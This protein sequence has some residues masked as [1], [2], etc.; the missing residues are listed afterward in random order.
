MYYA[1]VLWSHFDRVRN[2]GLRY[3]RVTPRLVAAT[4]SPLDVLAEVRKK[5]L[6]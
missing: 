6:G 5:K 3:T 4:T 2:E 1:R